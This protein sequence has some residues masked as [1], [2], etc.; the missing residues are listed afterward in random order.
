MKSERIKRI[1]PLAL[2]A[3]LGLAVYANS[4]NGKFVWDDE[5]LIKG[6]VYIKNWSNVAEIFGAD[7]S[8]GASVS[9]IVYRPL[10]IFTYA[11]DYS[12]CRL[13]PRGYH[14]TNIILHLLVSLAVFRLVNILFGDRVLSLLTALFFAAHPIHT[15][16]VSYISGRAD[17]L[18]AVFILLSLIFYI[19]NQDKEKPALYI[20]MPLSYA[21]ALLSRENSLILPLLLL[22]YHY[23]FKKEVKIRQF[24]SVLAV[25][26]VYILLRFTLLKHILSNAPAPTTAFQRL[27][28]FFAAVTGYARLII[29]PFDLHMEYGN[30]LFSITDPGAITG[31]FILLFLLTYAAAK[32]KAGGLIFFSVCWF[33]ITLLPSSNI[34]PINAYMAEHWLYLPS[35]GFFLI[36]AGIVRDIYRAKNLKI[37]ALAAALS[38]LA[39]YSYLTLKQNACWKEP[40]AVY[41]RTL[42]YTPGNVRMYNNLGFEYYNAGRREEAIAVFKKAI[43]AAPD[44]SDAYNNLGLAYRGAG[45]QNEAIAVFKKALEINPA[46]TATYNNLGLV[47]QEMGR[48][49]EALDIFKKIIARNPDYYTAY[50]N[51]GNVYYY[52]LGRRDDA[53]RFYKK[54]IEI[55]P[56]YA[57]P[58]Y[59]IGNIYGDTG[60][61]KEAISAYEKAIELKPDYF[62]AQNNLRLMKQ[63]KVGR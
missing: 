22:L 8:A 28:G 6:N 24:L 12:F 32:R 26:S 51:M 14:L 11:V 44:Y 21:F 3:V 48:S 25:T 37:I 34:Y 59:N 63:H 56:D 35:I 31:A 18:A 45:K 58:Y 62:E 27:P 13:N 15:E 5:V 53:L 42:K 41:E 43:E 10:Q 54:A 36:L 38:L 16:A 52:N 30:R 57:E 61:K 29:L 50:N 17:P 2:I 33:I 55:N 19:K 47:Y 7:I 20:L 60:N 4:L 46:Q 49:E 1:L 40:I 9:S 23:A 39:F